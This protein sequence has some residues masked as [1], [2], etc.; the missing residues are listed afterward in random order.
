MTAK[1]ATISASGARTALNAIRPG[2][3][4]LPPPGAH[5][6]LLMTVGPRVGRASRVELAD[7]TDYEFYRATTWCLARNKTK[8]QERT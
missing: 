4:L 7:L 8:G 5:A 6:H 2:N 1:G 3:R